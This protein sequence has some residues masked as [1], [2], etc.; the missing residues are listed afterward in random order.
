MSEVIFLSEKTQAF[1]MLLHENPLAKEK[2]DTLTTAAKSEIL[3]RAANIVT[4]NGMRQLISHR[5]K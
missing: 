4:L 2:F 1:Y 5:L 3:H